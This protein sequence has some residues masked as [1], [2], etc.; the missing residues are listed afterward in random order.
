MKTLIFIISICAFAFSVSAQNNCPR[1]SV[2]GPSGIVPNGENMTFSAYIEG[3]SLSKIGYKWTVSGGKI[4]SGQRT[5]ELIIVTPPEMIGET[6]IALVEISGLPENCPNTASSSH[7]ICPPPLVVSRL[8]D[9]FS[10]NSSLI[11]KENLEKIKIELEND[12]LAK[13]YI[14]EKFKRGTS[15]KFIRQRIEDIYRYFYENSFISSQGINIQIFFAEKNSTQ[16]WIMPER[17]EEPNKD[18]QKIEIIGANY[19]KQL[20]E[21]FPLNSNKPKI[22][23]AKKL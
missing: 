15:S 13:A 7:V 1:I 3:I 9:E 4:V 22:K 17:A 8:I 18:V 21:L 12:S 14:V 10:E 23:K 19:Q 20:N 11:K 2:S 6:T 5:A 16:F